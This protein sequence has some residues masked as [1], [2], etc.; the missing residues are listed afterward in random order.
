VIKGGV[1]TFSE[2]RT[3]I[4]FLRQFMELEVQEFRSYRISKKESGV[5]K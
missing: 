3:N 1:Q 4:I 2:F 5:G